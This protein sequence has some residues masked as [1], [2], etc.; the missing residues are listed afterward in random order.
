MN[1]TWHIVKK[2]L[3]ALKWPLLL[4]LL[5]IVTKLGIGVALLNA[6]GREGVE[7]FAKMDALSKGLT[8]FEFIS[9]VL[10]AALIQEDLLVGT[11]AFWMTR[12]ISGARLLRAKLLS[13][14]LVFGFMPVLV[15]LPW[16]LGC[17][18]GLREIA[19]AAAETVAAQAIAVL[20]GLLWAVVTDGFARFLM[21]TL[22]M[23][24]AIPTLTGTLAYYLTRGQP[25]PT[26]DLVTTRLTVGFILAVLGIAVVVVHQF[27]TRRTGRSIAVIGVTAGLIIGVGVWW[28]WTWGIESRVYS[29]LIRQAEGEWPAAAEPAGL[30]F[31]QVSAQLPLPRPGAR[32]G[33]SSVLQTKYRVEG[34]PESAGLLAYYSNHTWRWPDGTIRQGY[35]WSRSDLAELAA[36]KALGMALKTAPAGQYADTVTTSAGVPTATVERLRAEPPAYTLEARLRLIKF[37]TPTAVP[38]QAG[39]RTLKEG[40][41][42][43]IAGV[44]KSGEELLVTYIR[45]FPSL[46][47][48]TAGGGQLAP[49]GEFSQYFLVSRARDFVDHGSSQDYRLTQIGTVGIS[50]QTMK[51]RA[52]KKGGG[53]RPLLEAINALND[54][55]LF[56]VTFVEQARF[57]HEI[58]VDPFTLDPATP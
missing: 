25:S 18:Y 4:W 16:W 43:R 58:K 52:S 33:R 27:L 17:G 24:F 41:G 22:V 54:A 31:T 51:Y 8:A 50:W 9:F 2:D 35:T 12:P 34:L 7:W 48:H 47:V 10:V 14:G 37:E 39:P 15:T 29:Y 19:W 20:L 36:E 49:Y 32:A 42:E 57:T 21:W 5:L 26:S 56:K 53:S 44:E 38:L 30:K 40:L 1:L 28:P 3:R 55:E 46:L 6:D 23:L 11:T 13:I 45:H